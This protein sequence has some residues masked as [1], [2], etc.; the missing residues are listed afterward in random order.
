MQK[1]PTVHLNYNKDTKAYIPI[2]EQ[3]NSTPFLKQT[4]PLD[5]VF[6]KEHEKQSLT[7][8][9]MST[10]LPYILQ[11]YVGGLTIVGLYVIFRC[12]QT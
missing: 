12:T 2:I 5:F 8:S 11:M 7:L 1:I 4:G 10:Q 6:R 3:S 9:T